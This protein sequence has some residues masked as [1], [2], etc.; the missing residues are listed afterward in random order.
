MELTERTVE[1]VECE[2]DVYEENSTEGQVIAIAQRVIGGKWVFVI[3]YLSAAAPLGS[4]S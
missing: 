3:L 4:V 2:C 1:R